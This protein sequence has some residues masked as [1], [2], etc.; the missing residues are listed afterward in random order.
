MF[1]MSYRYKFPSAACRINISILNILNRS[2]SPVSLLYTGSANL[3][4]NLY[5]PNFAST[6]CFPLKFSCH[7][8]QIQIFHVYCIVVLCKTCTEFML[9]IFSL[10]SDFFM[11][12]CNSFLLLLIILTAFLTSG[13]LSL[14]PCKLFLCIPVENTHIPFMAASLCLKCNQKLKKIT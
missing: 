11:A 14:F 3:V 1:N 10:I 6:L 8:F 5:Q 2:R 9:K 4:V 7:P 12:Q 13:Q